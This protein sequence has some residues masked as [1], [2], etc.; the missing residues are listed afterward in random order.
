MRRIAEKIATLGPIGFL[1]IAAGSWGSAVAVLIWWFGLQRWGWKGQVLAIVILLPLAIWS[2][3][4][5]EKRLGHDAHPIVID[6][7]VGQWITLL[8][9]PGGAVWAIAG[10]FLFRIFDVLK[11]SPVRESQKMPGGWGIVVDDVLAGV[12]AAICLLIGRKLLDG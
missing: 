2:A 1:P 5:A 6:E 10:F 11:P 9:A 7:V 8:A 3:Q 4:Q 12:Y